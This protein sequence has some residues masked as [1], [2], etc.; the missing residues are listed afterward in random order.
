MKTTKTRTTNTRPLGR[1]TVMAALL[2]SLPALAAKKKRKKNQA[3]VAEAKIG[4]TVFASS[5]RLIPGASVTALPVAGKRKY[6][7]ITDR[8]GEYLVRIPAGDAVYAVTASANGFASLTK[9]I[10]VYGEDKAN[11]NFLLDPKL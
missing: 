11:A 10:N 7:A 1:R 8:R 5:G 9:T 6:K 3:P 4:G 2:A